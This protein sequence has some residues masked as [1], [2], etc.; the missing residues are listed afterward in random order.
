[1]Q[2]LGGLGTSANGDRGGGSTHHAG[3]VHHPLPGIHS[4]PS[5][6]LYEDKQPHQFGAKR[7]D[8]ARRPKDPEAEVG[9]AAVPADR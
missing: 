3:G 9:Q 2:T 1:M 5:A 8:T 4:V 7:Q 6:R